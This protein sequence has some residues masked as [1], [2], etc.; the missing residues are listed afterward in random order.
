MSIENL[1]RAIGSTRSV[2]SKVTPAQMGDATP[3][4]SWTVRDLVNHIIGEHYFFAGSVIQGS[5]PATDGEAPDFTGGDLVAA[6]DEAAKQSVAAF[7]ET[8]A[9]DKMLTMPFGTLPGTAFVGV[10]AVDTFAHGWDL[11]KATGQ[12]TDL[13]PALA[14]ELTP[15]AAGF[16]VDAV[17]GPDGVAP[18]GPEVEA[19][20]SAADRL[21]AFL[22]RTP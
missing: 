11:A 17:R 10:A 5:A 7:S 3:C 18:F 1:E 21:A 6:F 16:V 15:I 4:A 13:D 2:L 9:M 20:G 19:G 8:G 12:Q 22:G 14:D